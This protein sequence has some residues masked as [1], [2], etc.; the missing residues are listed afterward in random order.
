MKF[1][2][3]HRIQIKLKTNNIWDVMSR[4]EEVVEIREWVEQQC[5]WNTD[6]YDFNFRSS[7]GIIDIWFE[8]ERDAIMC[9]LRWS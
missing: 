3:S 8:H 9:A 5:E 1:K 2:R 6:N 4:V 7:T